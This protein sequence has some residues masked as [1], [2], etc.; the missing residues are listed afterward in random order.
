VVIDN[1]KKEI[2]G[3]DVKETDSLEIKES[4]KKS[5]YENKSTKK[6][7]DAG[8]QKRK[9]KDYITWILNGNGSLNVLRNERLS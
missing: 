7:K 9:H 4:L 6:Y 8:K 3:K 2:L 1:G 5:T